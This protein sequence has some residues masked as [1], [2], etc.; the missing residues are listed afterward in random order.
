MTPELRGIARSSKVPVILVLYKPHDAM[1]TARTRMNM[2]SLVRYLV[3]VVTA[4]SCL[5][6]DANPDSQLILAETLKPLQQQR[7]VQFSKNVQ[8]TKWLSRQERHEL[9]VQ[10][11][12]YKD[13]YVSSRH[14]S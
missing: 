11:G 9:K 13:V 12:Y 3:L 8:D 2:L 10:G 5:A 4:L 14:A 7:L 1:R 6:Q